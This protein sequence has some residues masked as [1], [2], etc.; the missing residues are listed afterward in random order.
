MPLSGTE[1]R[2]WTAAAL[3]GFILKMQLR[4]S[5]I[6]LSYRETLGAADAWPADVFFDDNLKQEMVS[7][8]VY[9]FN[10]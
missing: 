4:L 10:P 5:D 7:P 1:P 2:Q 9:L 8:A 6:I 3:D